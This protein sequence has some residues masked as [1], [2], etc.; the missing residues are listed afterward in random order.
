MSD[1]EISPEALQDLRSCARDIPWSPD[2]VQ[3]LLDLIA[4][5]A[6]DELP[7]VA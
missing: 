2:D 7:D 1:L 3:L 4:V 6:M 5:P